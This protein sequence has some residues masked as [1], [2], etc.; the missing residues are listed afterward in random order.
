MGVIWAVMLYQMPV[1][2]CS[3]IYALIYSVL[4][5]LCDSHCERKESF[6]TYITFPM[7]I[8]YLNEV[9]NI[10]FWIIWDFDFKDYW[11]G[12]QLSIIFMQALLKIQYV[13]EWPLSTEVW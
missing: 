3:L 8:L 10:N 11:V 4:M 5:H 2:L 1:Y 13:R 6:I 7:R 12:L 9:I